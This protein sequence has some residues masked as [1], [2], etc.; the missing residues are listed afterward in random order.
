MVGLAKTKTWAPTAGGKPN[1]CA[2]L[3]HITPRIWHSASLQ[4]EVPVTALVDLD[5]CDLTPD[6]D[7]AEAGLDVAPGHARDLR[8]R[9]GS[10]G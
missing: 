4:G 10:V 8:Y 9:P 3:F 7:H 2:S 1:R 5:F 6:P